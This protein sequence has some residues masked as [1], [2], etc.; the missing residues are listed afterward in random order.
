MC[1]PSQNMAK[2]GD[3]GGAAGGAGRYNPNRWNWAVFLAVPTSPRC[4]FSC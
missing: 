1:S 2:I 4:Y 3:F